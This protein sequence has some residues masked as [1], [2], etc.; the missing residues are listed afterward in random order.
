MLACHPMSQQQR[1]LLVTTRT[2]PV[3]AAIYTGSMQH[4]CTSIAIRRTVARRLGLLI[5]L[6][7]LLAGCRGRLGK[8]DL[9]GGA[10]FYCT[11]LGYT[12]DQREDAEGRKI[13]ICRF[14]DGYECEEEAFLTGDCGL[15][16]TFCA[17]H[18]LVAERQESPNNGPPYVLCRF[19]DG[20]SCLEFDY[21]FTRDKCTR[22]STALSCSQQP[23]RLC[24]PTVTPL[25]PTAT[26]FLP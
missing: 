23:G 6:A 11:A 18:G 8:P 16:Y 5:G 22:A 4:R 15:Q 17:R 12:L 21:A 20:S 19:P 1:P 26:P 7:F 10:S 9:Q 13:S 14:Y 25:Q 2:C 24:Q 3:S